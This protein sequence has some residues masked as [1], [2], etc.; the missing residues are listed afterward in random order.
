M[1]N[2]IAQKVEKIDKNLRW[3]KQLR[4]SSFKAGDK[5]VVVLF[6]PRGG[7]AARMGKERAD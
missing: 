7:D 5:A 3:S 1:N 2:F 6:H 4:N